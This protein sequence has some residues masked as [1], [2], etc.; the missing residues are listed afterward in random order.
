ML[1]SPHCQNQTCTHTHLFPSTLRIVSHTSAAPHLYSQPTSYRLHS[2]LPSKTEHN[3]SDS[4]HFVITPSLPAPVLCARSLLSFYT[5]PSV[6]CFCSSVFIQSAH[7]LTVCIVNPPSKPAQNKSDSA[8]FVI[9]PSLPAPNPYAHCPL[10]FYTVYSVADFC[11]FVLAHSVYLLTVRMRTSH[12]K[13][14]KKRWLFRI[15]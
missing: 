4:P 10:L 3:P 14:N 13:Q 6:S 5:F 2:N 1:I 12:Y 11:S 15:S 8:H 7:L 9:T